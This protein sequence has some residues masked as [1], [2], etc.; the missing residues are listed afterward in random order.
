MVG[1]LHQ[2]RPLPWMAKAIH[3][4]MG[5]GAGHKQGLSSLLSIGQ[6]CLHTGHRLELGIRLGS[7]Q[8]VSHLEAEKCGSLQNTPV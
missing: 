5:P 3:C 7:S 2:L 1:I 4:A 6:L 8:R